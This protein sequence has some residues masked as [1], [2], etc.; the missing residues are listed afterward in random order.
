MNSREPL[1]E[2]LGN[3]A[4]AFVVRGF[5]LDPNGASPRSPQ[6]LSPLGFAPFEFG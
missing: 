6:G 4:G 2:R 1:E 5:N 3:M